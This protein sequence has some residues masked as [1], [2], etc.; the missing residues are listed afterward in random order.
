MSV[1]RPVSGLY[2]PAGRAFEFGRRPVSIFADQI[3]LVAVV[4]ARDLTTSRIDAKIPRIACEPSAAALNR[5]AA[6]LPRMMQRNHGAAVAPG[7]LDQRDRARRS[8]RRSRS[9]GAAP[10]RTAPPCRWQPASGGETA[11]RPVPVARP[12]FDTATPT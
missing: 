11:V 3:T 5:L 8:W 6:R 9:R 12:A 4:L 1:S 7:K 2:L 10:S